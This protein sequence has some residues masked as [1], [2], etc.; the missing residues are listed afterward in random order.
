MCEYTVMFLETWSKDMKVEDEE[1]GRVRPPLKG[2]T[3]EIIYSS[4][5]LKELE[6][7]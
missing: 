5:V 1:G 2:F 4:T 3:L 6:V 7:L